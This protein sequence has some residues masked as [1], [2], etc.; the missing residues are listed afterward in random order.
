MPA[1]DRF[2][3]SLMRQ[4][5]LACARDTVEVMRRDA[6]E[7]LA[8]GVPETFADPVEDTRVR[9]LTLAEAIDVDRTALFTH[10]V[11][12]Y[13]T[14][15]AYRGVD[16]GYLPANLRALGAALAMALPPECVPLVQRHLAAAE[17][18]L[19]AAPGEL[20]SWLAGVGTLRG[21]ARRF[22]LAL[23]ENRGADA[24]ALVLRL[25]ADGVPAVDLHEHVLM[26]AMREIGRMWL[27]AEIPIADEHFASRVVEACIER[28]AADSKPVPPTGRKVLSFAVGG[29]QHGLPIRFVAERFVMRG[30]EVWHLGADMPASDLEWMLQDRQVD[31]VACGASMVLHLG[32]A[33]ATIERFRAS[34][35]DRCPPI[36]IGGAPFAVV[37]DLHQV[38]G[39]DAGA[40]DAA[41]ALARGEALMRRG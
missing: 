13:R 35:G 18:T 2:A 39:A 14:A 26:L 8:R 31:L 22:V 16:D 10:Q 7:L 41:T 29:D 24:I 6:A 1:V 32:S 30:H 17:A 38:L 3:A 21:E 33:R 37:P 23:L 34:S 20:P 9:I 4:G 27:M 40:G 28:L 11:A 5:A 36:L 19:R 25:H 15:L 12:W